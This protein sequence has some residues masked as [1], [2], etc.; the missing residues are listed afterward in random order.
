MKSRHVERS[1]L[2]RFPL[3]QDCHLADYRDKGRSE[4]SCQHR[5]P[6]TDSDI[7]IKSLSIKVSPLRKALMTTTPDWPRQ[8]RGSQD[9]CQHLYS[10]G[11]FHHHVLRNRRTGRLREFV[12]P[13]RSQSRD[14]DIIDIPSESDPRNGSSRAGSGDL[15]FIYKSCYAG[16]R[17]SDYFIDYTIRELHRCDEIESVF[18]I[19]RKLSDDS[20]RF[21]RSTSRAVLSSR[22]SSMSP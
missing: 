3:S 2:C 11:Q 22:R 7:E 6:Q 18:S 4:R 8:N 15:C 13:L 19:S 21:H 20:S 10:S 16:L 1:R 17:R 14:L 12:H 9:L 5:H